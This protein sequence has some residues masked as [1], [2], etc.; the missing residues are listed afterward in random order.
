MA[1]TQIKEVIKESYN[2]MNYEDILYGLL[3][4]MYYLSKWIIYGLL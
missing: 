1:L 3:N 2:A 4:I